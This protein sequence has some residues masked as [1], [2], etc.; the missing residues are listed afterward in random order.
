MLTQQTHVV[1]GIIVIVFSM[2]KSFTGNY[3]YKPQF[4]S[5][6]KNKTNI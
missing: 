3:F 2:A 6:K 4:Q 1:E 5:A